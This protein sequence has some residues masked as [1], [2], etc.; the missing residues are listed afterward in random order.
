MNPAKKMTGS[1]TL[2][3][4]N[5]RRSAKGRQRREEI[6][7]AAMRIY[8]RDGYENASIANIAKEVGLSLP[9]LLHYFPTKADLLLAILE[10]RDIETVALFEEPIRDWRHMFENVRRTVRRNRRIVEVVRAFAILNAESLLAGHPALS[11]FQRR[12]KYVGGIMSEALRAG[13]DK[14]ELRGDI[15]P[16]RLA[17]EI[18]GVWDGVQVLWLREP[19]TV[20]IVAI[21]DAYIDRLIHSICIQQ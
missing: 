14:G 8:S 12:S 3:E 7:D 16:A 21:I 2:V 17:I 18:I 11:W 15:D 10:Q 6:L 5:T 19:E 13:M 1:K 9:G 20:D 4:T